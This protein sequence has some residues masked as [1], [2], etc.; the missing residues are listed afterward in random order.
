[1]CLRPSLPTI[2]LRKTAPTCASHVVGLTG[3]SVIHRGLLRS[4]CASFSAQNSNESRSRSDQ[5]TRSHF[6]C[7]TGRWHA[8][9]PSS[10][11]KH[12]TSQSTLRR[13][14]RYRHTR[15]GYRRQT[16]DERSTA[17]W[18]GCPSWNDM[19]GCEGLSRRSACPPTE[20]RCR[21][22]GEI[23]PCSSCEVG[24]TYELVRGS[25]ANAK[26]VPSIYGHIG[27][28]CITEGRA[29]NAAGVRVTHGPT[30]RRKRSPATVV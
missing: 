15:V 8:V 2:Q 14:R 11:S 5:H 29:V 4:S 22:A 6:H 30:L 1:M 13:S 23:E 19:S 26:A 18:S 10:G 3:G 20:C 24:S 27:C 16:V 25:T 21:T 7:R 28:S 17:R 9:P 12:H